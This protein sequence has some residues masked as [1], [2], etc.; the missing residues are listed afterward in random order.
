MGPNDVRVGQGAWR[1][2]L[3]HGPHVRLQQAKA[4]GPESPSTMPFAI[5]DRIPT[6]EPRNLAA[7]AANNQQQL[8][9]GNEGT[10]YQS[11]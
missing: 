1:K 6:L 4:H 11:D 5:T 10:R 8:L 7:F 9:M 3:L 2:P